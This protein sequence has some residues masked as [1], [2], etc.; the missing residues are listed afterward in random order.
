MTDEYCLFSQGL[1]RNLGKGMDLKDNSDSNIDFLYM[2]NCILVFI[3]IAVL[4]VSHSCEELL[5]KVNF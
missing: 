5:D 1:E 3:F 2:I 4:A